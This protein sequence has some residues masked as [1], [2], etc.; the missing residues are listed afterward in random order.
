[1]YT[2]AVLWLF[3]ATTFVVDNNGPLI[4]F[5][6]P[7]TPAAPKHRYLRRF[8]HGPRIRKSADGNAD[9]PTNQPSIFMNLRTSS[10][11]GTQIWWRDVFSL[12]KPSEKYRCWGNLIHVSNFSQIRIYLK[13]VLAR[14]EQNGTGCGPCKAEALLSFFTNT[15]WYKIYCVRRIPTV[16][17]CA[18]YRAVP[19]SAITI[20]R[21]TLPMYTST[22]YILFRI[23]IGV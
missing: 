19:E 20:V 23:S 9:I 18:T 6:Y 7:R 12:K 21:C 3:G 16:S 10:E 17:I 11:V 13:K 22:V 15:V 14:R 1:M 8:L 5:S 2:A 4:S